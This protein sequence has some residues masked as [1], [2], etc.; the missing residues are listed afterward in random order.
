MYIIE[1]KTIYFRSCLFV[2]LH[3]LTNCCLK[4]DPKME[5]RVFYPANKV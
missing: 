4:H 5:S 2:D 3:K 1:K